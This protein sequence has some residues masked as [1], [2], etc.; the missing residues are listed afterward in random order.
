MSYRLPPT[1]H[2]AR[3][4]FAMEDLAEILNPANLA[5]LPCLRQAIVQGRKVVA[6]SAGA[7]RSVAYVC[8]RADDDRV[9][10]TVGARGGWKLRWN[11]G[12]GRN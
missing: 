6:D 8:L 7:I 1:A 4:L 3:E 12:N 11:F 9:L 10:I 2:P 5:K